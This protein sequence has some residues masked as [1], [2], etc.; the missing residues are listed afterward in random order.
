MILTGLLI[1]ITLVTCGAVVKYGKQH[2]LIAGYNTMPPDKKK[3]VD[4][5]GL[6]NFMAKS[7]FG[8][9]AFALAG[10]L[11]TSRWC[12]NLFPYILI[13]CTAGTVLMV[14]AA[15]KFD[16]NKK[17]GREKTVL[18]AVLA[19]TAIV[20]IAVAGLM[21]YGHRS[22]A[23]EV[24]PGSIVVSGIYGAAVSREEITGIDLKNE[25]PKIRSKNNGFDSGE[26][27]KGHFTLDEMGRGRLYLESNRAPFVCI[28]TKD[29]YV[30]INYKDPIR[31][32]ALYR[33]LIDAWS[34]LP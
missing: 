25:I 34:D 3:N 33:E 20:L 6:A 32:K 11:I 14:P 31:T 18:T 19:F 30:I 5:T 29:S 15:Q 2:W 27:R 12:P 28:F 16:H 17:S 9:G 24:K 23:V 1:F 8:I 10:S 26:V 13:L 21:I 4:I 22:P 7:F